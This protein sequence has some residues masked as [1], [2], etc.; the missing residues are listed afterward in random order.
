MIQLEKINKTYNKGKS[1]EFQA[2]CNVD[3]TIMDGEMVAVIGKSG[4]GK[5]TLLHILAGIDS[6]EKGS[7]KVGNVNVGE[8]N[9]KRLALFRNEKVGIVMQDFALIEGYTVEENIMIPLI[10]GK[11]KSGKRK[12]MIKNVLEQLGISELRN[13]AVNK[14][15]GGQKQRVAIA[16]AIVNNPEFILADEP[17]G[18]LDSQTAMDIMN[19]FKEL[20]GKGHTIVIVT[21]DL[22]LAE[23]CGRIV[24]I[25]DGRIA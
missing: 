20:N 18:A 7:Y 11:V 19:V 16:R 23:Q 15:S 4:A 21:H 6:F 2:L 25:S 13:K 22:E 8:L 3:L 24:E 9:E 17:T 5:S 1:N 14:L 10:F 12:D